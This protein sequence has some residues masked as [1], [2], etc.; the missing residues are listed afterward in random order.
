MYFNVLKKNVW[1]FLSFPIDVLFIESFKL[2]V[3]FGLFSLLNAFEKRS[4]FGLKVKA[5]KTCHPPIDTVFEG[6]RDA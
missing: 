2:A 3:S 6:M 1:F 5:A 4:V